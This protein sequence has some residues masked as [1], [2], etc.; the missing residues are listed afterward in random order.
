M[1]E[2]PSIVILREQLEPYTGEKVISVTGNA[3]I[4]LE[5]IAGKKITD[6]KSWGKHFL[7]CFE[8]FFLRIHLLMFGTYRINER[9][10]IAPRLSMVLKSGEINFYTCSIKLIEGRAEEIYNWETDLMSDQWNAAKVE[11]ELKKLKKNTQVCDALLNQEVF[12]GSGN[13]IKNEVL[14]RIKMHPESEVQ[15]LPSKK[16]KE[17]VKEARNYSL[18]F[19]NWKKVFELKKHWLIYKKKECPRCKIRSITTYMGV[20]NRLTCYCANCQLLYKN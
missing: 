9:K 2:G 12:S 16:L 20:T 18:D 11:K 19:Y 17:L 14:F 7:I 5:R 15:A 4:D 13:I 8:N 3:K 6:F 10:E 1:P